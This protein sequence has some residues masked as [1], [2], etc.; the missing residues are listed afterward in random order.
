MKHRESSTPMDPLI[1][2]LAGQLRT[3]L[4]ERQQQADVVLVGNNY[5]RDRDACLEAIRKAQ[6]ELD[7]VG[8]GVDTKAN[9]FDLAWKWHELDDAY[10]R[11]AHLES[12][13]H[14]ARRR[15][16]VEEALRRTEAAKAKALKQPIPEGTG[17]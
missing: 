3:V 10:V 5:A 17:S 13:T 14:L 9:A 12:R 11:L 8:E 4:G 7:A 1:A 2:S 16:A 6:A 15:V